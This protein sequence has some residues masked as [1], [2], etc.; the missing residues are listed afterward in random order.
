MNQN[1]LFIPVSIVVA[2]LIIAGAIYLA[3]NKDI[4]APNVVENDDPKEYSIKPVSNE[5]HILGNPD[6]EIIIVEYSDFECPFCA[7]F[8]PTMEQIMSEYGSS[9]KVAW[10]FRHFPLD[11]AHKKARAAAEASECVAKLVGNEAFWA[12][13]KN[14]FAGQ[15]ES[16][17]PDFIKKT[18][19]SLG[20][21]ESLYNEC[22][23]NRT[24]A[25]EV[26]NDYQD[27]LLIAQTDP[28]F[29]TPYSIVISKTG[30]QAS[31]VGAQPYSLVKQIVSTMLGE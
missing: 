14:I 20:V 17:E 3:T 9:G 16:L 30:V 26:E 5:D 6:A 7:E 13:G 1:K 10:V 18:A 24:Y 15:P 2:G 27:G 19:L 29:G 25:E 11:N 31:I 8:H 22:V 21:E 4:Q 12:F 28:D 23:Q